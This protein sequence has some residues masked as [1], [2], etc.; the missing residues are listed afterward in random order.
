MRFQ[1]FGL[2]T[3]VSLI[4]L[5][6][7]VY[8]KPDSNDINA[9]CP[10]PPK[11]ES[12]KVVEL[13]L[14]PVSPSN[15]VGA[16][17]SSIN[18]HRSGCID[19]TSQTNSGNFLP[20][21]NHIV[22]TLN[23]VGAPAAPDPA[24]IYSGL[25]LVIIRTNGTTFKNGDSWKCITC[26]VPASQMN[27]TTAL[28]VYPQAFRD[29]HRVLVGNNIV[30]GHAALET[31]ACTPNSTW[32][33][34]IRWNVAANG[35]GA[36]GSIRELR[37]HPDNVHLGFNAFT[38]VGESS[39]FSRLSFNPKPTIGDPISARYDLDNVTMFFNSGNSPE[40]VISGKNLSIN[41]YAINVGEFR[42]FS[43]TGKEAYY[44][45]PTFESD[46]IDMTA[47]DLT[48]GETRRITQYPGYIDPIDASFDDQWQVILDT[49]FTNRTDFM[50]GMR[51]VPPLNDIIAVGAAASI[52]NNGARRYFQPWLLNRNGDCGTY[53]GQRINAEGDGSN[54]AVN[55]PNWNGMA[56][57]RWS[58]DDT[59]ISYWQ[60]LVVS[61][62]CGGSNPLPC[63]MSTAQGGRTS[64]IMLAT[65]T[66][67]KPIFSPQAAEASDVV[68]WGTP[69]TPGMT[70][71][72][73]SPLPAGNYTLHGKSSG[74]ASVQLIENA[75]KTGL[76]T[77]V[78]NYYNYSDD[79]RNVLNGYE[80]VTAG[81]LTTTTEKLDWYSNLTSHGDTYSTK[82]TGP[83]GFHF[84]IDLFTNIFDA[85]GTLTTTVDGVAYK[86]PYNFA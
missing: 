57:P 75:A 53:Y 76:S 37:I 8:A 51:H 60:T 50:D 21:G 11:F 69:Y 39:F 80:N 13:G 6:T 5:A 33:Y 56:D 43:K 70:L 24:S 15:A 52:R 34:P 81:A 65:L 46:N 19:Q 4:F 9:G 45:G 82:V 2:E 72:S 3:L 85:N 48:T 78:A 84:T 1:H 47:I 74:Y 58:W 54:G 27:G 30:D 28:D 20:D 23:F 22:A 61:P 41:P 86:Q 62:A 40:Y 29:G 67:R 63:P 77:V 73:S 68:P 59:K 32:I 10:T 7:H 26:G 12:I 16:C 79:G 83:G 25:H 31:D 66:N 49:R 18:P 17:S 55:D 38:A 35:T 36:G 42:G 44:I 71:P 64:R 14:P